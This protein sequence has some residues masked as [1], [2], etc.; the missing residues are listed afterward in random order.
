MES[1]LLENAHLRMR[2]SPQGGS[3]LSLES[4]RFQQPVLQAP[5]GEFAL[6]PMLPLANRVA[7]N[8]FRFNEREIALPHHEADDAFFLHGDGW[9]KKWR[10]MAAAP[11]RCTL[12]LHS[13][14]SCGYDYEA[15]LEYKLTGDTLSVALTLVHQGAQ[16]M[17]YGCGFHPWFY[18]TNQYRAQFHVSGCWPEGES[19]LPLA[20]QSHIPPAADFSDAQYGEDAWLNMGY[21]GWNGCAVIENDV[22][23]VTLLAQT[24]YLMA[25][26]MSGGAFLCLEPQTHPV[27]AH[28]LPGQPGLQVLG[29]GERLQFSLKIAVEKGS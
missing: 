16:P 23:R 3:L 26:R 12:Q 21:S 27:N 4:L 6:F 25:F 5:K 17:L 20:W 9:L 24:P 1:L 11:E 8:R 22:M 28:N 29:Q 2:V 10:V 13:Q 7:N 15:T 18:F 14:L 19:H